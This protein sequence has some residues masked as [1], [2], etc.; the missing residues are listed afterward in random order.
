LFNEVSNWRNWRL[1]FACALIAFV[2]G[3]ASLQ[4][5]PGDSLVLEDGTIF[6]GDAAD[7]GVVQQALLAQ[8]REWRGTP[9]RLGGNSRNGIDC[10][11]FVQQT[12]DTQ[13]NI[14]APRTTAQQANMGD[15]VPR[16]AL[17]VGDLL[18]FRTGY[19]TRHVGF[20]LGGG[21]FLHA[22]TKVGVTISRLDDLYWRK[23]F[24]KV[25]RV[26]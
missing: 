12:L 16:N 23:T 24:W 9:Y 1:V 2:Q 8:F 11:A 15:E 25:R 17:K 14:K 3:C 6:V 18:F 10:S 19:S 5:E 4:E 7:R 22:S 26:M 20:Y 13:F 21:Q